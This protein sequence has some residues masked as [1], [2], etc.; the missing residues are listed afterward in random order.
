MTIFVAVRVAD[1]VGH[2]A[3]L[4]PGAGVEHDQHVGPH[5]GRL[6]V[7]AE[8]RHVVLRIDERDVR[9]HGVAVDDPHL[10]AERPQ[11]AAPAPTRCRSRRN[12]GACGW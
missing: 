2:R 9:R 8:N 5:V 3:Q 7:A 10:L 11:R 1:D 6:H 12:R 4:A